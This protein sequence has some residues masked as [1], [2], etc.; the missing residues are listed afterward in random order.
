MD[1]IA[2]VAASGKPIN[3]ANVRDA[4]AA[5]NLKTLQGDITFDANGDVSSKVV[6]IFQVQF[7]TTHP[8]NDVVHQFKYVGVAPEA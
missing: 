8:I 6:S 2:R 5:T 1:A 4:I 7:D 3:R